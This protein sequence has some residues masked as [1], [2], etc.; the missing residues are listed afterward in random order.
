MIDSYDED[1]PTPEVGSRWIW[2]PKKD[3]AREPVVV[4]EVKWNGEEWWVE[5]EGSG[6]CFMLFGGSPP[7]RHWNDLGRFWEAVWPA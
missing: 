1:A 3:H 6:R 4:T 2:E 7:G 5:T